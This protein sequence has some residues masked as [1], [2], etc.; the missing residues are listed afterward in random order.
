MVW[1][2]RTRLDDKPGRGLIFTSL[3]ALRRD[4]PRGYRVPAAGGA[5]FTATMWVVNR[6]HC[7]TANFR[8]PTQPTGAPSLAKRYVFVIDVA[9]LTDSRQTILQHHP[10][11]AGGKL[12]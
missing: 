5:T 10:D 12:Y 3:V 8:P 7:D 1:L 2:F 11:F 4:T 9:D 6:V